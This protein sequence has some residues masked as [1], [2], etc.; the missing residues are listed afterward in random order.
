MVAAPNKRGRADSDRSDHGGET[1]SG[2]QY[3]EEAVS[4]EPD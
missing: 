4:A 3:R 1:H 2:E